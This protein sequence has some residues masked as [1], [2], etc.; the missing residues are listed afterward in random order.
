M[1]FTN[2]FI[3]LRWFFNLFIPKIFIKI[4]INHALLFTFRNKIFVLLRI[5][6][7]TLVEKKNQRLDKE[8]KVT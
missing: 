8:A 2:V 3:T 4:L 1:N 5:E 6:A 7:S